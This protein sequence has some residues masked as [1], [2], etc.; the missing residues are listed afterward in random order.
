MEMKAKRVAETGITMAQVMNPEN[1]NPF[2]NVHGGVIMKLIDTA[3]GVVAARHCRGN[4]VTASIERLD[5]HQPVF[6]GDIVILKASINLVSRTSMEVGVRVE[7]ENPRTGEVRW[8]ASAHLTYVALDKDGR[9]TPV[10]PLI[11]E[12]GADIRRNCEAKLR[13]EAR[14]LAKEASRT[15]C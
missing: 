3:G 11:L 14:Q 15:S 6:I 2:G 1:A 12:T 8:T 4:V 5:F 10:P 9:P 13:R 7:A